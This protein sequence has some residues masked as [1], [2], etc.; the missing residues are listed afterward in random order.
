VKRDEAREREATLA[1][2]VLNRML[3]LRSA[4]VLSGQ[5][6]EAFMGAGRGLLDL[7]N[8]ACQMR[9]TEQHIRP[10]PAKGSSCGR[11]TGQQAVRGDVPIGFFSK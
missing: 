5:L 2:Q 9:Y 1:C 8:K 11:A 4:S 10:Y 7:C 6:K 3:E